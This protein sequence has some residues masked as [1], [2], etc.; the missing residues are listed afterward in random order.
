MVYRS[1]IFQK[2]AGG[3]P[4]S[5]ANVPFSD[6]SC[7]GY[8]DTA[9]SN[10]GYSDYP[11]SNVTHQDYLD[12]GNPHSDGYTDGYYCVPFVD[13]TNHGNTYSDHTDFTD[14][15]VDNFGN[16][17]HQDSTTPGTAR[18]PIIVVGKRPDKRIYFQ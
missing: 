12:W 14:T 1:R 5:H 16:T 13:F 4:G 17:P 9:H 7:S 18:P 2:P 8:A 10:S 11:H 3:N 6:Y 15:H